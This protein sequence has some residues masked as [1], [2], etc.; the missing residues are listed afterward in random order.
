MLE[1]FTPKIVIKLSKIWVRDPRSGIR[2]KPIP[3]PGSRGQEGTGS[4]IRIRNTAF[5]FHCGIGFLVC[6]SNPISHLPSIPQF[7]YLH[8]EFGHLIEPDVSRHRWLYLL[9]CAGSLFWRGRLLVCG[10]S[11]WNIL[12]HYMS[13]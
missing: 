9:P 10:K 6:R 4:R 7:L 3:D 2:K 1:L 12:F 13:I 8:V 5:L 11:P